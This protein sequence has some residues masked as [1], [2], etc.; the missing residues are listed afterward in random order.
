MPKNDEAGNKSAL[1]FNTGWAIPSQGYSSSLICQEYAN[2]NNTPAIAIQVRGDPKT[3]KQMNCAEAE[4]RFIV[5]NGFTDLTMVG[6]STGGIRAVD[7]IAV[8]QEKNP[9]INIKGLILLASMGLSEQSKKGFFN[10]F[11]NDPGGKVLQELARRPIANRKAMA[12]TAKLVKEVALGFLKDV[13]EAKGNIPGGV[14]NQRL[15]M[16]SEN[17]ANAQV[18]VPVVLLHGAGD[19]VTNPYNLIPEELGDEAV[20]ENQRRRIQYTKPEALSEG[21]DNNSA[22]ERGFDT[23]DDLMK[24][25]IR[26]REQHL[27]AVF[28]NSPAIR[29]IIAGADKNGHHS[30]LGYRWK[31][32]ARGTLEALRRLNR[33]G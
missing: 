21:K 19:L 5:E 22:T 26:Q 3:I 17:P 1:I 31:S 32:A 6:N 29:M 15:E 14:R 7:T 11:F 2:F 13:K 12:H 20:K 27:K 8:L 23:K 9:E 16:I 4:R 18:R 24:G 28:P 30:I 25:I 10:R 33:G